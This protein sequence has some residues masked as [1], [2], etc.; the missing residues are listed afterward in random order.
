MLTH[1]LRRLY[2][3]L[4]RLPHQQQYD[5]IVLLRAA[6][7]RLEEHLGLSLLEHPHIYVLCETPADPPSLGCRDPALTTRDTANGPARSAGQR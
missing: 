6:A 1:D 4:I 2:Q 7:D 5:A 3:D